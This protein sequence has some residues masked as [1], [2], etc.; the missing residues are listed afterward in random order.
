MAFV[1]INKFKAK[2]KYLPM[3]A[4]K[5]EY[6]QQQPS[7]E[8]RQRTAERG[9]KRLST[10]GKN[11]MGTPQTTKAKAESLQMTPAIEKEDDFGQI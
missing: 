4:T 9:K 1:D 2:G 5:S 6:S 8:E 11:I 10:A 3:E 7:A